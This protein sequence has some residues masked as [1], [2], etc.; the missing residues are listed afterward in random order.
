MLT[1]IFLPTAVV[2]E[3]WKKAL[4]DDKKELKAAIDKALDP[5]QSVDAKAMVS[6][7]NDRRKM[8]TKSL[9]AFVKEIFTLPDTPLCTI[10]EDPKKPTLE[11]IQNFVR[12]LDPRINHGLT[13]LS[14]LP[15]P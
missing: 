15:S 13:H 4:A 2:D 1:E 10:I 12:C 8:A 5:S 3:E 11:G 6:L 7:L 14:P 9:N